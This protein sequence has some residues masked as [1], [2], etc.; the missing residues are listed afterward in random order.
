MRSNGFSLDSRIVGIVLFILVLAAVAYFAIKTCGGITD[1][2]L[3]KLS[4]LDLAAAFMMIILG[5]VNRFFFWTVLTA[6]YG[7]KAPAATASRA[8]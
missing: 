2:D 1:Y 8:D 4:L 7:L 6:S 5:F 3:S